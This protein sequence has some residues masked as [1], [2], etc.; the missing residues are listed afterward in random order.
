MNKLFT[1]VK[2]QPHQSSERPFRLG[3]LQPPG[4]CE[5]FPLDTT[6]SCPMDITWRTAGPD[7]L[8]YLI[9]A[10]MHPHLQPKADMCNLAHVKPGVEVQPRP[11]CWH[12]NLVSE[13]DRCLRSRVAGGVLWL[14]I[15]NV[16]C[17]LCGLG[18]G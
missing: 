14:K 13:T 7:K 8:S 10:H 18:L 2:P 4:Q 9:A 17:T 1:L 16:Y 3:T 12:E 5:R 15:R 11:V 6:S